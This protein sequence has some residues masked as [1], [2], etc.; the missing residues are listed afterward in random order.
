VAIECR[1]CR[2]KGHSEKQCGIIVFLDYSRI[3]SDQEF[4]EKYNA[5]DLRRLRCLVGCEE[6]NGHFNCCEYKKLNTKHAP[7]ATYHSQN[8]APAFKNM[9]RYH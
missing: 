4:R 5:D 9:S 8:E 6:P 1:R 7:Y 2:K 3:K